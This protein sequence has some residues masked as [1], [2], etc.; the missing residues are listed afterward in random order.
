MAIVSVLAL[1][2]AEFYSVAKHRQFEVQHIK[3]KISASDFAQA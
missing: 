1:S 2:S 3:K